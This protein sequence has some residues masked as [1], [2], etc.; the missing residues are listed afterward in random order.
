MEKNPAQPL[1]PRGKPSLEDVSL[2]LIIHGGNARAEACEALKAA[3]EG[4]FDRAGHHMEA[5]GEEIRLGHQAQTALLQ[6][7]EE[8]PRQAA[9]LLF[10]HAHGH[11]MTAISE[12]MLIEEI[13]QLY[14][15]L[16]KNFLHFG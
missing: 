6:S 16:K 14:Q 2:E 5:A 15:R 8:G 9:D 4:D 3:R 13:I 1:P 11:L 12:K 10:V 7:G